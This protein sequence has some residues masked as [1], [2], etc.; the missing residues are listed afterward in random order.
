MSYQYDYLGNEP[1]LDGDYTNIRTWYSDYT[2]TSRD[3]EV[4][5]AMTDSSSA[6]VYSES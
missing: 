6:S 1:P 2:G 4:R 3:P 5:L